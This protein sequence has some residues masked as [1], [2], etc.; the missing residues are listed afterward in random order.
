MAKVKRYGGGESVIGFRVPLS[1]ARTMVSD[2]NSQ[3]HTDAAYYEE[4]DTEK[5][6]GWGSPLDAN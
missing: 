4:F 1:V 5:L 2:W 3:Y 6:V